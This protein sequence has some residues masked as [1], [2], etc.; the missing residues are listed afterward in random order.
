M[1]VWPLLI[2]FF[3]LSCSHRVVELNME[4]SPAQNRK[5][6]TVWG[7]RAKTYLE[8]LNYSGYSDFF[9]DYYLKVETEHQLKAFKR[10]ARLWSL[11]PTK[12]RW[13]Y[14]HDLQPGFWLVEKTYTAEGAE[15]AE[16]IYNHFEALVR[17]EELAVDNYVVTGQRNKQF[18]GA[19][20]LFMAR[21]YVKNSTVLNA[22]S[23]LSTTRAVHYLVED[24]RVNFG[25]EE[26]GVVEIFDHLISNSWSEESFE[27]LKP[28]FTSRDLDSYMERRE[29][30][31]EAQNNGNQFNQIEN[32]LKVRKDQDTKIKLGIFKA[33]AKAEFG[34]NRVKIDNKEFY[35]LSVDEYFK[36]SPFERNRL[37]SSKDFNQNLDKYASSVIG[38]IKK[39]TMSGP[40]RMSELSDL[41]HR[42]FSLEEANP[43]DI[44]TLKGNIT[45]TSANDFQEETSKQI[46]EMLD[47]V[48]EAADKFFEGD[49][50]A[51]SD[52]KFKDFFNLLNKNYFNRLP[53]EQKIKIVSEFLALPENATPKEKFKIVVHNSGPNYQKLLQMLSRNKN[54]GEDFASILKELEADV[55]AV[56]FEDVDHFLKTQYSDIYPS[57]LQ[58]LEKKE[59]GAGTM[60]Q[61]YRA[62]YKPLNGDWKEVAL[63]V[64]R[65][66]MEEFFEEESKLLKS[67]SPIID[68]APELKGSM[69]ENFTGILANLLENSTEELSSSKTSANQIKAKE[70]YRVLPFEGEYAQFE[71]KVFVPEVYGVDE[72]ALLNK[73]D[74][75]IQEYVIAESFETFFK[76]HPELEKEAVED[77]AKIW[78]REAMFVSGFHHADPHQGNIRFSLASNGKVRIHLLDY[79]LAKTIKPE[80]RKALIDLSQALQLG[81][82]S[83]VTE[84]SNQFLLKHTTNI[85]ALNTMITDFLRTPEDHGLH[86]LIEA[87]S[88]NGLNLNSEL[89]SLK[90]GMFLID[91][92]LENAGSK[93]KVNTLLPIIGNELT[94]A[95]ASYMNPLKKRPANLPLLSPF[96]KGELRKLVLAEVKDQ[97]ST[98][99]MNLL[100]RKK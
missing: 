68:S 97:C 72:A 39:A 32:K 48:Q 95:E 80:V 93:Q 75:L 76:K 11:W 66:G 98:W 89:V 51:V 62:R 86:Q 53:D 29:F 17:A 96:P 44:E 2:I 4:R 60:A 63:R 12:H 50:A 10:W 85:T 40:M 20:Q 41:N 73:N 56:P 64:K 82:I 47:S 15:L 55:V 1:K 57:R 71:N 34:K 79:G 94:T 77:L 59:L 65:P 33:Q 28:Y 35:A 46:K 90:R 84:L 21:T 6:L 38:R 8:S 100:P 27:Y 69:F 49:H 31:W 26:K 74:I 36:L 30:F 58:I 25:K 92:L 37:R 43:Q 99:F 3:L 16:S 9:D 23:N 88:T 67:I 24:L 42:L 70:V 5:Q 18:F 7:I 61:T 81:N 22:I 52:A 78:L 54:V 14:P 19:Y 87:L 13:V 83:Q 45:Y 91:Q